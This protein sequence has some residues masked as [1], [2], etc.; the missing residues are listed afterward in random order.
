MEECQN[1]DF[2]LNK[3]Q[4]KGIA[5]IQ[6][7]W[8]YFKKIITFWS[9]ININNKQILS[10]I[11]FKYNNYDFQINPLNKRK[12]KYC[13]NECDNRHGGRRRSTKSR[14]RVWSQNWIKIMIINLI[15]TEQNLRYISIALTQIRVILGRFIY[16][17]YNLK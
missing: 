13:F 6:Q 4:F 16:L 2:T 9:L 17:Y 7:K 14:S 8:W 10:K 1:S 12:L 3:R 5:S 11:K 15:N